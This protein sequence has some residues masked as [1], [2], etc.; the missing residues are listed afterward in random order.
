[1]WRQRRKDKAMTDNTKAREAKKCYVL[2]RND[3]P[4]RVYMTKEEADTACDRERAAD[5]VWREDNKHMVDVRVFW[6]V[7]EASLTAPAEP[8]TQLRPNIGDE[9]FNWQVGM[10]CETRS[11]QERTVSKVR[12]DQVQ[13]YVQGVDVSYYL[14]GKSPA[15]AGS[16][17]VRVI[18]WPDFPPSEAARIAELE[19]EKKLLLRELGNFAKLYAEEEMVGFRE[20]QTI[21][22][23]TQV[24]TLKQ[25]AA[26]H[27]KL[28]GD[29]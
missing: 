17:L 26:L 15:G 8:V 21:P 3:F 1:M 13:V 7:Y 29:A 4:H 18:K 20:E 2:Q 16:D 11:G 23:Y 6:N 10:V 5:K 14:T 27:T 25:A 24:W 22:V 9:G 12:P 19:A 28:K